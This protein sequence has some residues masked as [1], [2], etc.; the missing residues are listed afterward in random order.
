MD[1]VYINIGAGNIQTGSIINCILNTTNTKEE[2]VI[3]K[4]KQNDVETPK[5][6]NEIIVSGIDNIKVNISSCC[7]PIPGDEIIG[8]VTK[9][10]GINVH[11]KDCTNIHDLNRT[12]EVSWNDSIS[13]RYPADIYIKAIFNEKLLVDVVSKTSIS[14]VIIQSMNSKKYDNYIIYNMTVMVNNLE[15]LKKFMVD[16][17]QL[18]DIVEIDRKVS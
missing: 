17:K 13:K 10:D 3:E 14:N 16:L 15:Q 7:R 9:G 6:K 4:A 2:Q 1:D 18:S 5:I 8:Y 12:I 11:R